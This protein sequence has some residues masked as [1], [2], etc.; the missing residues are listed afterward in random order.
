[1]P[2]ILTQIAHALET[3]SQAR[4][5][6]KNAKAQ[7]KRERFLML[8]RASQRR[9]LRRV[10]AK[11]KKERAKALRKRH[12]LLV[13]DTPQE[14]QRKLWRIAKYKY[15]RRKKAKDKVKSKADREV[16]RAER[17]ALRLQ[18]QQAKAMAKE[19]KNRWRLTAVDATRQGYLDVTQHRPRK[20][21]EE[22]QTFNSAYR[23]AYTR[24]WSTDA[25]A[26]QQQMQHDSEANCFTEP[27]Q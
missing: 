1:M 13:Q 19:L 6:R 12:H 8:H 26:L 7:A 11:R 5:R 2:D 14:R 18:Q 4:A 27:L 17:R 25:P 21:Q 24:F 20:T 16:K 22:L 15:R 10:R 9:Y 23:R 3:R